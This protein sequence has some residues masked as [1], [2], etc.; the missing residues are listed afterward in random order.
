[1]LNKLSINLSRVNSFH[2]I[3][4]FALVI[5]YLFLSADNA[6]KYLSLCY[7]AL[8]IW[9]FVE[10][11]KLHGDYVNILSLY[12]FLLLY[13]NGLNV[14]W[15]IVGLLDMKEGD[16]FSGIPISAA[17]NARA[18]LNMNLS[19]V[20]V[21]IGDAITQF[22]SKYT[23][24]VEQRKMSNLV[25]YGFLCLGMFVKVYFSLKGLRLMQNVGY[26]E[27]FAEASS[28]PVYANALGLL[29][30]F[31]ILSK[32]NEKKAIWYSL[33]I[34]YVVLSMSTGQRAKGM[35]VMFLIIYYLH[36]CRIINLNLVKIVVIGSIFLT[37]SIA[38]ANGRNGEGF[39]SSFSQI[40]EYVEGQPY[41][42]LQKAVQFRDSIDYSF[43]D[44]FGHIR[45]AFA[46]SRADRLMARATE[47]KIWNGYISYICNSNKYFTGFGM[48]GNFIGQLFAV[49]REFAVVIGGVFVGYFL[50]II[51]NGMF[52]N[53]S[54]KRF[55]YFNLA[56]TFL[57]ITRDHLFSFMTSMIAPLVSSII[58]LL[59]TKKTNY[60]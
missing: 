18:L 36:T 45:S 13:F 43:T 11:K 1:M 34:V 21:V 8:T 58:I 22:P 6:E 9:T 49:G 46:G 2:F 20:A 54:L 53:N 23:N 60:A 12:T 4:V 17:D 7:V 56:F 48:G 24:I 14:I 19:L 26:H 44:M 35:M 39:I 59:C 16:W 55:I 30:L 51:E 3:W 40:L 52:C 28:M 50:R 33:L 42:V 47:F 29:A 32:I 31:V 5:G 25:M 15:D 27:S 57:Y 38:I 41:K 37:T 10:S